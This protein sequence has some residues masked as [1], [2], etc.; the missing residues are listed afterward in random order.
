MIVA[1]IP[2]GLGKLVRQQGIDNNL[3][4]PSIAVQ[5]THLAHHIDQAAT[6]SATGQTPADVK[7]YC[8]QAARL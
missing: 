5:M 6:A 3:V 2:I 4:A 7:G 8:R 1:S